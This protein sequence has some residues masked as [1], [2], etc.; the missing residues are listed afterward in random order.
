[1][2]DI[3]VL[4]PVD[5]YDVNDDRPENFYQSTNGREGR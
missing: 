1:M 2:D 4:L 5:E 3:D